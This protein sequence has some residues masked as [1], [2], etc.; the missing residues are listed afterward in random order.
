[1]AKA[2]QS[3]YGK[4]SDGDHVQLCLREDGQWFGRRL[5]WRGSWEGWKFAD[6]SFDTTTTN[7]ISGE[8]TEHPDEPIPNWGWNRLR[9]E[10]GKLAYRLPNLVKGES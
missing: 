6:P 8:V 7:R 1:M 9:Q 10:T 5:T 4:S 2:I 3:W